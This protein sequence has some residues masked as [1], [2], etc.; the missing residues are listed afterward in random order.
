MSPHLR[1][2]A[3]WLLIV[4]SIASFV[5]TIA[6]FDGHRD[7]SAFV[8]GGAGVFCLTMAST[9]TRRTGGR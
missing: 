7:L 4:A 8:L 3:P 2:L 9:V 1:E 5:I 6:A